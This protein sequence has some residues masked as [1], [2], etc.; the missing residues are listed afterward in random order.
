MASGQQEFNCRVQVIY[1][2]VQNAPAQRFKNLEASVNEFVNN[3]RWSDDRVQSNEK[4][5]WSLIINVS[6]FDVSTSNFKA[7]AQILSSRPVYGTSYNSILLDQ[8]DE[9]WY[10]TYIDFQPMDFTEGTFTNNLISL[11]SFYINIVLGLDA[12]S[13]K[14]EGGTA[15]FNKAYNIMLNAQQRGE[16]GWATTDAGG[17]KNRYWLIE[18][19]LNDRFKPLREAYYT[20]HIKGMD[21]MAKDMEGARLAITGALQQLQKVWKV[22][23]NSMFIKVWFNAKVNEIVN[24]YCKALIADKNKVI[25]I[26]KEADPA[27]ANKYDGILTCQ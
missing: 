20:Y 25:A 9:Q 18:N 3:R 12:D 10:F 4:I 6:S 22:M 23:P 27:N 24:I 16:P 14:L 11:V 17:S 5:E 2:Q 13:F 7:T 15:Y 21:I 19:I 8:N 1:T 26:L